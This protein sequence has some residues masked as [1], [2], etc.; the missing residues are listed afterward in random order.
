MKPASLMAACTS[1]EKNRF[2]LRHCIT[3]WQDR[4]RRWARD[5]HH[6]T[7]RVHPVGVDACSTSAAAAPAGGVTAE[8]DAIWIRQL[9]DGRALS[10]EPRVGKDPN[11]VVSCVGLNHTL[12]GLGGLHWHRRLLMIISEQLA[13]PATVRHTPLMKRRSALAMHPRP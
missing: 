9:L 2:L 13:C 3:T 7:P 6:L 4:A 12:Q 11:G 10:E 1:V 5:H 8:E